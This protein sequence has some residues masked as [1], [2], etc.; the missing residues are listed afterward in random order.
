MEVETKRAF[1]ALDESLRAK[2][3]RIIDANLNRLKE[4]LR[5]VEDIRRYGYDDSALSRRIKGLRHLAKLEVGEL[6]EYRDSISDVLKKSVDS[7]LNRTNLDDISTANLKRA[8]ESARVLEE[9]FK[10]FDIS[11]S[12]T[13]K[14]IRYELYDIE[15]LL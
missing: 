15:K 10:L 6:L 7:E 9:C 12:E 8:Q 14:H 2:L 4:G 1:S 5:V 11:L 13:F 3:A